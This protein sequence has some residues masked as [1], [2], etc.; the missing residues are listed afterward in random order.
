MD[1]RKYGVWDARFGEWDSGPYPTVEQARRHSYVPA[2]KEGDDPAKHRPS[3]T[4]VVR[5]WL[6]RGE[7]GEEVTR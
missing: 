6:K 5:E 4:L 2:L 7:P 3:K 1:D